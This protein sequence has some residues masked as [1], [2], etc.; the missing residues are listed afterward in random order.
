VRLR[1]A[2]PTP[3]SSA[4]LTALI[5]GLGCPLRV[6]AQVQ[7]ETAHSIR[8]YEVTGAAAGVGVLMLVDEPVQRFAQRNRS[9]TT[10][11]LASVFRHAGQPEVYGT[12]TLGLL[13]AGLAADR[14]AITR[15]GMRLAVSLGLAGGTS[16]ALKKLFGRARPDD[17][18]GAFEFDPFTH[19]ESL[20]SGHTTMAFALAASLADDVRSPVVRVALYA[21]ATGTGLSRINDN[22]HWVSDVGLG[23]LVGVTSAKLVSGRWR[24]F[25][26]APPGLL[27]APDGR[28]GLGWRGSF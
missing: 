24:V 28:V 8:W 9:P 3:Y 20:P 26:I 14:P 11:D 1:P 17:G 25:G 5:L 10:D 19:Y 27:I 15:A 2:K 21:V 23:A 16:L 22:R 7:P 13:G 18:V 4:L 12:V 6:R